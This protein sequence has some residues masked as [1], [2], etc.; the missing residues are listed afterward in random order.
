MNPVVFTSF[1]YP[2]MTP[3]TTEQLEDSWNSPQ[4]VQEKGAGVA[5]CLCL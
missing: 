1:L 4:V 2:Y 5:L 3:G